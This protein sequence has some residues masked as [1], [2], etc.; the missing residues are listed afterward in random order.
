MANKLE[1]RLNEIPDDGDFWEFNQESKDKLKDFLTPELD[2]N[3][4]SIRVSVK[5][6]GN[7]YE[8]TV[9]YN[10]RHDL[11]CSKCAFEF[12]LPVSKKC[13]EIIVIRDKHERIDQ[14]KSTLKNWQ[15]D[16]F[17]TELDKPILHLGHFIREVIL[18]DTPNRP[19]AYG[20]QCEQEACEPI[21]KYNFSATEDNWVNEQKN[22][23][24]SV[25]KDMKIKANKYNN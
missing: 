24:F 15:D 22:Q 19:L 2:I 20:E 5:P 7:I 21:K 6:M 14:T 8:V 13:K 23:P 25:L 11:L 3:E 18:I 4:Y 16:L 10:V 17:C 9:D 12:K 1:V